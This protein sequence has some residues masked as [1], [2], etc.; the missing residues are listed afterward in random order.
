MMLF[1]RLLCRRHDFNLISNWYTDK[2]LTVNVML[3]GS[4]TM[5]SPFNDFEFSTDNKQI[6]RVSSFKY[7]GVI[8]HEESK[9]KMHVNSLLLKLGHLSVFSRLK[10]SLTA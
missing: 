3:S 2:S 10:T 8:L 7:L 6:I 9:W 4:K 1:V 5:L